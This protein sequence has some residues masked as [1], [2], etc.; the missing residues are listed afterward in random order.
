[1]GRRYD[2]PVRDALAVRTTETGCVDRG[3]D[4]PDPAQFV[5]RGRRYVVQAVLTRW[6]ELHPWWRQRTSEGLPARVDPAGR[7]LWRVEAQEGRTGSRGTYDLAYDEGG[8][9]WTL[10]HIAD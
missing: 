2:H 10:A 7:R 4:A 1:M 9:S 6:V 5:W 3:A 8:R